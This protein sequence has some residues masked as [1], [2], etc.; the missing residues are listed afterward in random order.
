MKTFPRNVSFKT[1]LTGGGS[2][3][4]LELRADLIVTATITQKQTTARTG[5]GGATGRGLTL[6]PF[7]ATGQPESPQTHNK[8]PSENNCYP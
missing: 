3:E 8:T 4:Q 5:G 6:T 2:T 7:Q 1:S